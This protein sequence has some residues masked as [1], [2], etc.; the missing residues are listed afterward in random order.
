MNFCPTQRSIE[1]LPERKMYNEG[2]VRHFLCGVC[3]SAVIGHPQDFHFK[4][5]MACVFPVFHK[6]NLIF[7]EKKLNLSGATRPS[8]GGVPSI[9]VGK[10]VARR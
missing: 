8:P 1:H 9:I 3:A 5:P 10:P 4:I 6:Q 7:P 2:I